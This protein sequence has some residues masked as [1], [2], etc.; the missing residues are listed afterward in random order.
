MAIGAQQKDVLKMVVGRGMFL[1]LIGVAIGLIGAFLLTRLMSSLLFGVTATDPIT[2]VAI[3][4]LLLFV[5]LIA[6]YIPAR[7]ASKL[8]PINAL[9]YE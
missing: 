3:S 9:R 6:S 2:F 1:T 4:L 5:A 7:R 8:D